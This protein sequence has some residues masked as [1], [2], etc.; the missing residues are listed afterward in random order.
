MIKNLCYTRTETA[1]KSTIIFN[2]KYT[3]AMYLFLVLIFIGFFIDNY[4]IGAAGFVLLIIQWMY[5]LKTW[6]PISKEIKKASIEDYVK[7][8]GSKNSLSD[9]ITYTIRK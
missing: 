6:I 7:V 4:L 5:S 9:P 2:T 1:T 8:T 3:Y